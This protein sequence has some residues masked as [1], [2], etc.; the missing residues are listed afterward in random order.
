M[1]GRISVTL[2]LTIAVGVAGQAQ[3]FTQSILH[4]FGSSSTDGGYPFGGL[5][6]DTA[7]NLYGTNWSGGG[8]LNC[9]PYSGCG[10]VFKLDGGGNESI[11]HV[12]AGGTDGAGP[13][14]S[15]TLDGAGNLYGT[16]SAGGISSHYA[17]GAG[18]V[19]KIT[20]AGTY[21]IL[22]KFGASPADGDAPRGSLILDDAGNLYGTTAAGGA[23]GKGTV[24]GL[25][26]KGSETVLYSFRGKADGAYPGT[27]LLRDGVGNLYGTANQGGVFG[28]GVMF[29]LT[30]KGV[31]TALHTFCSSPGCADGEYPLYIVRTAQ[32]NFYG[33][34]EYGGNG[35]GVIFEVS[36]TGVEST[37]YTFCSGGVGSGCPDGSGP[38]RLLASGGELYGTT[39]GGGNGGAGLVY[40]L[41]TA[42][43]ETVLYS[44]P[45]NYSEGA[46]PVGVIADGSG[47]LY[48]TALNGGSGNS[49]VAFKLSKN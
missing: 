2:A 22:H 48:G 21:S 30:L 16:T 4:N 39:A 46:T 32:G 24:F 34:A 27:N 49:G 47:N 45:A 12:F 41:T 10:T 26:A 33:S 8:S 38:T 17:G 19:F 42:G 44:F 29:K 36:S 5:V 13:V 28:V 9:S 25:R 23:Y 35:Q 20:A 40:E 43:V 6:M 14:A 7:G 15:L 3:T 11:L 18:T 31:L 1:R 37:L